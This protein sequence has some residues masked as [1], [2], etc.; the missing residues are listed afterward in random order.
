ML[1]FGYLEATGP[2]DKVFELLEIAKDGGVIVLDC[3]AFVHKVRTNVVK[4]S[5]K[6]IEIWI[7]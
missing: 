2:R 4:M 6:A 3:A 7:S 1:D 5:F